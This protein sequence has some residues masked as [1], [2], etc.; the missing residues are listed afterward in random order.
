VDKQFVFVREM[1]LILRGYGG[2]DKE[3]SLFS[4]KVLFFESLLIPR[5]QAAPFPSF[6]ITIDSCGVLVFGR[7]CVSRRFYL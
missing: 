2:Q 7:W 6:H 3:I 4:H 5:W 1:N